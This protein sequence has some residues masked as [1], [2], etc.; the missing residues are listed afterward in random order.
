VEKGLQF[1]HRAKN[2][3][4]IEWL[5]VYLRFPILFVMFMAADSIAASEK[6]ILCSPER[7]VFALVTWCKPNWEGAPENQQKQ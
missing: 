7:F 3:K 5:R 2:F 4:E 1:S 6:A